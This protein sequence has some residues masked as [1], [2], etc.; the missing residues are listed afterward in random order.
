M[1]KYIIV[2][3]GRKSCLIK[4]R[5]TLSLGVSLPLDFNMR[6]HQLLEVIKQTY[7]RAFFEDSPTTRTLDITLE[8]PYE[9]AWVH[10]ENFGAYS[11]EQNVGLKEIVAL[12]G[13]SLGRE[14]I[15]STAVY[16]FKQ[17]VLV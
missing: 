12:V 1:L 17:G 11:S 5:T 10:V 16:S 4:L 13:K 9:G 6:C 3:Q 7:P 15:C 2:K 14:A 8:C